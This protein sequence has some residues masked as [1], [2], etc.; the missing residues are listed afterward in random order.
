MMTIEPERFKALTPLGSMATVDELAALE[1]VGCKPAFGGVIVL[2]EVRAPPAE[3]VSGGLEW[4]RADPI[5][6]TVG[7]SVWVLSCRRRRLARARLRARIFF[8]DSSCIRK[9]DRIRQLVH[10]GTGPVPFRTGTLVRFRTRSG[11]F[12]N[13]FAP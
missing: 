12:L 4:D 8:L 13:M 7:W 9:N 6:E 5:E 11:S 3:E 10:K 1:V 2:P